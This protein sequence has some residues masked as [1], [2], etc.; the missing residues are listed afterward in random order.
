M[1]RKFRPTKNARASHTSETA[2]MSRGKH[3]KTGKNGAKGGLDAKSKS[4]NNPAPLFG[5]SIEQLGSMRALHFV[6]SCVAVLRD[7]AALDD[8]TLFRGGSVSDDAVRAA[9]SRVQSGGGSLSLQAN[10]P[11]AVAAAVLKRWLLA[12]PEPL[13]PRRAGG[14]AESALMALTNTQRSVACTVLLAVR[15]ILD[16]A[17]A[18]AKGRP[19]TVESLAKAL[20]PALLYGASG[21]PTSGDREAVAKQVADDSGF[22][23]KL[24]ELPAATL[25]SL[26]TGA[27][28][29][30]RASSATTAAGTASS[31]SYM[32]SSI[33][34]LSALG[35]SIAD[36]SF[37]DGPSDA[38]IIE[39]SSVSLEAALVADMTTLQ[40][41]VD[42]P[43]PDQPL[44]TPAVPIIAEK[45]QPA[46]ANLDWEH[47]YNASTSSPLGEALAAS[48]DARDG[49]SDLLFAL[50]AADSSG[51]T[52]ELGAARCVLEDLL[53]DG[54][55][56]LDVPL[57]ILDEQNREIGR[58]TCSVLAV[59]A[60]LL[61]TGQRPSH[62]SR[63]GGRASYE[64][65]RPDSPP[66]DRMVGG[67]MGLT[68]ASDMLT[69][70]VASRELRHS[71][72]DLQLQSV[73]VIA[74]ARAVQEKEPRAEVPRALIRRPNGEAGVLLGG[75]DIIHELRAALAAWDAASG[76]TMEDLLTTGALTTS[77]RK[78]LLHATTE[79]RLA[80]R[81]W[82]AHKKEIR[83]EREQLAEDVLDFS[84]KLNL[85]KMQMR[86]GAGSQT[87]S[88]EE[89]KDGDTLNSANVET[90]S[91]NRDSLRSGWAEAPGAAFGATK[92][93]KKSAEAP[94]PVSQKLEPDPRAHVELA[95]FSAQANEYLQVK[96][97]VRHHP[98]SAAGASP[99][100]D[101]PVTTAKALGGPRT[102]QPAPISPLFASE[103]QP[104]TRGWS[105]HSFQSQG[106]PN[107]ASYAS[108]SQYPPYAQPL[109]D[110]PRPHHPQQ[111]HPQQ[112]GVPAYQYSQSPER[113]RQMQHPQP[114]GTPPATSYASGPRV[115]QGSGPPALDPH[116]TARF[117]SAAAAAYLLRQHAAGASAYG[118][119]PR[120]AVVH[121]RQMTSFVNS[122]GPA[123]AA[124]AEQLRRSFAPVVPSYHV[125]AYPGGYLQPQAVTPGNA[126]AA[127]GSA[128]AAFNAG[129]TMPPS[130]AVRRSMIPDHALTASRQV[131]TGYGYSY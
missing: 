13:I 7:P 86:D 109:P 73:K 32:A 79:V 71:F 103:R 29:A 104:D 97:R 123:G 84:R 8:P 10:E 22:A 33:G 53:A 80:K 16:V 120:A 56:L 67:E 2:D 92:L 38:I 48:L 51:V 3:G 90:G 58:I 111:Q 15:H 54:T 91:A 122:P 63:A 87:D 88:L 23:Q 95:E 115:V 46:L 66:R 124:G 61:L 118:L 35:P 96:A 26:A 99:A 60:L 24:L 55:D 34:N 93:T 119:D 94:K 17:A 102:G 18:A 121:A 125:P 74:L 12:M 21:G 20:T 47:Q 50:L 4:L 25:T 72:E 100:P 113:T 45:D 36:G 89:H 114:Q 30:I 78:L 41:E 59:N 110:Q 106:P 14:S 128:Q 43:G 42:M 52:K 112:Q 83:M 19:P 116:S 107:P 130:D 57:A 127:P 40:I 77:Q 131:W 37:A 126:F 31:A 44:L 5:S 6:N 39:L 76:G 82:A 64:S 75:E 1:L 81:A 62:A 70:E 105:T 65:I 108:E 101:R 85:L 98:S 28:T 11:P 49:E 69:A 9:I 27:A 117:M 68:T 129:L